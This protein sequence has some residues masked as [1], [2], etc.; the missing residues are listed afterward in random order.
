MSVPLSRLRRVARP[1]ALVFVI[2]DFRELDPGAERHLGRMAR[3]A[4]IVLIAIHD[5]IEA[6]L[7]PP[8]R[9]R[10]T[11]GRN[12]VLLDSSGAD[13]RERYRQRFAERRDALHGLCRRH[14]M[15]LIPVATD[16]DPVAALRNA[17]SR[18]AA[19]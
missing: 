15:S 18:R 19:A 17:P 16:E 10:V 6:E 9:Y 12:N 4:S 13:A 7:P 14:G 5:P 3:H 2:S 11:D 8:G 1:G